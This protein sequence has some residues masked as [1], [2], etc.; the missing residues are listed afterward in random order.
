[1][2]LICATVPV[3]RPLFAG[4]FS[5]S[6]AGQYELENNSNPVRT[7]EGST[8]GHSTRIFA[9]RHS[10]TMGSS[11]ESEEHIVPGKVVKEVEYRVDYSSSA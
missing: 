10:K 1:M 4:V 2:G 8:P 11:N 5:G 9:S 6:S 3:L 7:G